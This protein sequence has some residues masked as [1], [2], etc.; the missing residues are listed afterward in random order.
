MLGD[1]VNRVNDYGAKFEDLAN[2]II[3]VKNDFS[4]ILQ[5]PEIKNC[6]K[7]HESKNKEALIE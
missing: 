7:T 6:I 4:A 1:Y 5:H 2:A 3:D